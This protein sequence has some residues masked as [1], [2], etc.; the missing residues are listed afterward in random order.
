MSEGLGYKYGG[1]P[2]FFPVKKG[3]TKHPQ[4]REAIVAA[5]EKRKEM[6]KKLKPIKTKHNLDH[7]GLPDR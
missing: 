2:Y 4:V 5:R 6:A 1:K 3:Y 7:E